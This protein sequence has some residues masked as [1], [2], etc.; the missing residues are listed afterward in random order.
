MILGIGRGLGTVEYEGF[1]VDMN[2]S[3]ER[4]V[5]YAELILDGLETGVVE[6]DGEFITQPRREI[7]PRPTHSF[8]GRAYAASMSPEAMP[9]MA[10]LGVGVLVVP[11]KDWAIVGEDLDTYRAAWTACHG[12]DVPAPAPLCAGNIVVHADAAT[13]PRSSP[14]DTSGAT[15]TR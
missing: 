3:R 15:T 10:Q 9:I 2:T 6:A 12:A 8:R 5:E 11:Q 1:R 13:V 14:T 7:R 4:F